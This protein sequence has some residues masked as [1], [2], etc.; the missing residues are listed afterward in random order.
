[1]ALNTKSPLN[2]Y[3][4][5]HHVQQIIPKDAIIVSEGKTHFFPTTFEPI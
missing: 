4:V 1:M 3:T 5:F 2:Y